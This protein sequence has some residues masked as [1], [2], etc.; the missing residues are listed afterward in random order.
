[1]LIRLLFLLPRLPP[2]SR[3]T[4]PPQVTS[5]FRL[6]IILALPVHRLA[7]HHHAPIRSRRARLPHAAPARATH[8]RRAR[9]YSSTKHPHTSNLM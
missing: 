7:K 3:L 5:A 9:L 8:P 1:M 2:P 6:I 4:H